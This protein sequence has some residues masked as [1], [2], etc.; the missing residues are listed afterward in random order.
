MPRRYSDYP[1]VY[2][3]WNYASSLGS[4]ISVFSLFFLFIILWE[5]LT[6]SRFI[7]FNFLNNSFKEFISGVPLTD[8][9][10]H[11]LSLFVL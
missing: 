7:C 6:A 1:D 5:G 2:G 11:Q 8:H 10:Y 4:F 9:T 3:Q